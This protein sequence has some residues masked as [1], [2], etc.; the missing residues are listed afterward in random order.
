[1]KIIA[2]TSPTVVVEE[3]VAVIS[4]LLDGGV[5]VVHLR[6]P[7]SDI[8]DC[9]D[10][11]RRLD[12]VYLSRIVVHDYVELY[13][14]FSLRGVHSN[15][16]VPILPPGYVGQRS[17]S[18]HSLDEVVR[19]K[20][21]CDYL[22]LSPIFDS[23]SKQGYSSAFGS[24]MLRQAAEDGIIDEKVIALGG[25]T[26]DK[27]PYLRDLNFGGVAMLGALYSHEGVK[28]LNQINQYK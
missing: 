7:D 23:I 10:L 15:R 14:E 1:M 26:F 12:S 22:F 24:D 2:I 13:S 9:R 28:R 21:E 20:D 16:N 17:R 27:L 5:D 8:D 19:Y 3:D 11:L 6:K 4:G 25:V 18:C